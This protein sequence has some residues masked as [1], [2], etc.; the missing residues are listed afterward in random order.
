MGS[1]KHVLEALASLDSGV[2]YLFFGGCCFHQGSFF[3]VLIHLW[4]LKVFS[5]SCLVQNIDVHF[6]CEGDSFLNFFFQ[7]FNEVNTS[8][9][10]FFFDRSFFVHLSC[11]LSFPRASSVAS[12][13]YS[14]SNAW[15]NNCRKYP[16]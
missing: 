2:L 5:L 3:A 4:L 7:L 1:W 12:S 9:S 13:L 11:C 15:F 16:L 8:I 10:A 14:I 6:L